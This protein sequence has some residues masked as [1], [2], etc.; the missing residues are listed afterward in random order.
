MS[1]LRNQSIMRT[2]KA[3]SGFTLVEML[4][5]VAL[6]MLMMTMFATILQMAT[7]SAAK[8]RVIAESDQRSR[9]L[10]S[11]M[12]ADFSKR[13]FRN[14]FPFLPNEDPTLTKVPFSA[15]TGYVYISCN[16]PSSSTDDMIQFTMDA[17]MVQT[18]PDSSK[19]Y[20]AA[21]SL[22]DNIY[23][24]VD[25][26]NPSLPFNPN[27][28]EADDGELNPN[29]TS[30]S[31]AA[32][33]SIFLRG[34]NLIRRIMLIRDPLAA[35]GGD[36]ET[37]PQSAHGNPPNPFFLSA[38]Q[39]ISGVGP[40]FYLG[41]TP[42]IRQDDFWRYFDFSAV[43]ANMSDAPNGVAFVGID[44]L[45]NEGSVSTASFGRP[46]F[47]FGF[48]PV[49]GLSREHDH[50]VDPGLPPVRFI[51][52]YLHAETSAPNFNWPIGV[53]SIGNPMDILNA[54]SILPTAGEIDSGFVDAFKGGLNGRGGP[55]RVEDVLMSNVREF[56]IELWDSR[57]E[58]WVVP[59]H[60]TVR[61]FIDATGNVQTV[62]GD[63]HIAR[64]M[65]F[66]AGA[67]TYGP[68]QVPG[69]LAGVPHVFD[70]WHPQILRD[71][72]GNTLNDISER[73]APYTPLKY[74]PPRQNEVLPTPPG[75]SS[76][77]MP[78]ASTEFDPYAPIDPLYPGSGPRVGTNRG[79]WTPGTA[80]YKNDV[81]FAVRPGVSSGWDFDNDTVFDWAN[82]QDGIPAQSVHV[83]YRCVSGINGVQPPGTPLGTSGVNPPSW[84]S[85][86]LRFL[87]NELLWEGFQNYEPLKSVRLTISFIEPNSETPKQ[88]TLILPM[89]DES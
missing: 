13:S 34:G 46:N 35:V 50:I 1:S 81:V 14:A 15:R 10:T 69:V 62:A 20:G 80:Y 42:T 23:G 8:Q 36:L 33:I 41:A 40:E 75:P 87:D 82:D 55:R 9:Q 11:I 84:Q 73:Q 19:Y 83:A 22:F 3:K 47:R 54:V 43:P 77:N 28:P 2:T 71:A 44:A 30:S 72:N 57:L 60:A 27:Q 86:G 59:G 61:P 68:L 17:R 37:Q 38:A 76:P 31:D 21:A 64:N 12:R 25:P 88:L 16:N 66:G 56:K 65:Q 67:Y 7:G 79:Y 6:V 89:T 78:A 5:A 26:S 49:T 39:S 85:P 4:V 63:Y 18:N 24:V 74:Y 45:S 29:G 52:R 51:G 48:N 32:E 70:T 58:R 53:S